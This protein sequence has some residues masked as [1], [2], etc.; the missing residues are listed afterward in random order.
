MSLPM[1]AMCYKGNAWHHLT[2]S[3]ACV[4][5]HSCTTRAQVKPSHCSFP[6][7]S[8]WHRSPTHISLSLIPVSFVTKRVPMAAHL[9]IIIMFHVDFTTTP[10]FPLPSEISSFLPSNGCRGGWSD[11]HLAHAYRTPCT[12]ISQQQFIIVSIT[13][14]NVSTLDKSHRFLELSLQIYRKSNIDYLT[15]IDITKKGKNRKGATNKNYTTRDTVMKYITNKKSTTWKA[16]K[17]WNI[18]NT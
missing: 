7:F 10:W 1:D 15:S 9:P 4:Y 12:K 5:R 18:G 8:L 3:I 14:F 13:L 17:F 2:Y 6:I 11:H 16:G